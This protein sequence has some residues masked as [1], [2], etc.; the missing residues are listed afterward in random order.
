MSVEPPA[1]PPGADEGPLPRAALEARLDAVGAQPDPDVD[2]AGTALLLA[3]LDRPGVALD[4]Y[5]RHLDTLAHDLRLAAAGARDVAAC[6]EALARVMAGA[7][8]YAGDT[9][10]YDDVQNANL[11]RVIDRRRGLPVALG[12]LY[13]HAARAQGWTLVGLNFPG[14]FLVRL[15]AAG[16]RAIIDPFGG[17]DVLEAGALREL[18]KRMG[19][20]DAELDPQY[21]EAVADRDVLLR[22]QNN[23]KLRALQVEDFT[24][25][26]EIARSMLRIAPGSAALWHELGAFEA[27]RG[28]LGEAIMALERC[29]NVATDAR[30]RHQVAL[31]LQK[32]RGS[33]N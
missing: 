13:A 9:L 25:A 1:G 11:M 22:L 18:V 21:Y 28:H 5:R 17:G 16:G 26:A 10:S 31:A 32:I 27:Q 4:R 30:Q 29:L 6:A 15:E 20:A 14:H 2:L 23:I 33:L 12:I 3:A 24:R 19:G 8:N 7:H